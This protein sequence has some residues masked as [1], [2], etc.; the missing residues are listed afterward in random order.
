MPRPRCTKGA[1]VDQRLTDVLGN[2]LVAGVGQVTEGAEAEGDEFVV[3]GVEFA[4][5]RD[6][7]EG[8]SEQADIA[9]KGA[10]AGDETGEEVGKAAIAHLN[11]IN[12][13]TE[14][15]EG[16]ETRKVEGGGR[17]HVREGGWVDG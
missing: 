14:R 6:M 13:V 12:P 5:R 8:A 16:I 10:A 2:V 17:S 15:A 7:E 11:A 9:L 4:E 3:E 1:Y